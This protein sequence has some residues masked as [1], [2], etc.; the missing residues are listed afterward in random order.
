[1]EKR[2]SVTIYDDYYGTLKGLNADE[3]QFDE[4]IEI[5]KYI[6]DNYCVD[7]FTPRVIKQTENFTEIQFTDS[8]EM[9]LTIAIVDRKPEGANHGIQ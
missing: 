1:M 7:G 8:Y 3:K 4:K 9:T 2:F 5:E 6:K